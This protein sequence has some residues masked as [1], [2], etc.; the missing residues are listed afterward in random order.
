MILRTDASIRLVMV[1]ML[2]AVAANVLAASMTFTVDTTIDESATI[3]EGEIWTIQPG[4]T[5]TINSGISVVNN[6]SILN[7][8]IIDSAGTIENFGE[9]ESS[10]DNGS[11]PLEGKV[12]STGTIFNRSGATIDVSMRGIFTVLDG[13]LENYG[14]ITTG[15]PSTGILINIATFTNLAD[16]LVTIEN[17]GTLS[18]HGGGTFT[19]EGMIENQS[20][21]LLRNAVASPSSRFNNSGVISNSGTLE[22]TNSFDN[23]GRVTNT[24]GGLLDNGSFFNNRNGGTLENLSGGEVDNSGTLANQNGGIINNAGDLTNSDRLSNSSSEIDNLSGGSIVNEAGATLRNSTGTMTNHA[25]GSIQ[26]FGELTTIESGVFDNG[27]TLSNES[28][29]LFDS[30]GAVTNQSSGV[31]DN[32]G[33]LNNRGSSRSMVP[34]GTVDNFG[35]VNNNSGGMFVTTFDTTTNTGGILTNHPTALIDNA[36]SILIECGA[37]LNQ[38][39]TVMGL[40]IDE[41]IPEADLAI[42]ISDDFFDPVLAGTSQASMCVIIVNN[43]PNTA[44]DVVATIELPTEF[45]YLANNPGC[46]DVGAG[47][48]S[49]S[50]DLLNLS[51]ALTIHLS[52]AGSGSSMVS[53][54]GTVT[55]NEIDPVAVNNV[56]IEMTTIILP[57]LIFDDGFEE[58]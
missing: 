9:F 42:D 36:G 10:D 23:V 6:G 47:V 38:N 30:Y 7:S 27:G 1:V 58:P 28:S 4:V 44:F 2:W 40:A 3:A 48:V 41:C 18:N 26:N 53:T 50:L 56:D 32:D 46:A 13:S 24:S 31:F 25:G 8:G 16:G 14:E 15:S 20:G 57:E 34:T 51:A 22:N 33:M 11:N 43:G 52:V 55:A 39:G 49:C 54:L 5:L 17:L 21:G 29:A 35:V 19:N 45:T 12:N 37:V